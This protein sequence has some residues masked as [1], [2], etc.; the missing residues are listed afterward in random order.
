MGNTSLKHTDEELERYQ[1][2][3][4]H[5]KQTA[6][7]LWPQVVH[8][9]TQ[10]L[11][12]ARCRFC[13]G[14]RLDRPAG[15]MPDTLVAKVIS[16]LGEIPRELPLTISPYL[17]NE[18]F[19]DDR[20]F[21]ILRVIN[22][23]LP[24]ATIR[25]ATNGTS[26]D[27]RKLSL[28]N[29]V[30]NVAQLNVSVNQCHPGRYR[31]ETGLS[32]RLLCDRLRLIHDGKQEGSLPF[33][34]VL[35][36]VADGSPADLEFTRWAAANYPLFNWALMPPV[37]WIGAVPIMTPAVPDVGCLEWFRVSIAADGKVRRCCLDAAGA[38]VIGDV[39]NEHLLSI[40][41]NTGSADLR[42][43]KTSRIE[44]APC[45]QCSSLGFMARRTRPR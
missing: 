7:L 25:L 27:E 45:C 28:L 24:N 8:L 17:V 33:E 37:D 31:A 42:F 23:E 40:Y 1:R 38:F 11:C 6:Y 43:L 5:L 20:L 13:P 18:P 22:D 41:N 21:D 10:T 39:K 44:A 12:D 4:L 34:I 2:Q 26:L 35:S 32:Y 3:F 14:A 16:D 36:R 30:R 15:R 19:L 9:E 29:T